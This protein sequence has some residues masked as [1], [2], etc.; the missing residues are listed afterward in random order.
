VE[1][2][3]GPGKDDCR[4]VVAETHSFDE[5][6]D[7]DPYRDPHLIEDLDSD[8]H[9]HQSTKATTLLSNICI[10]YS[11]LPSMVQDQCPGYISYHTNLMFSD[12]VK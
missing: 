1:S 6:Q 7:P 2:Q 5:E 3:N 8:P 4:P 12:K 11:I 9:Q 10:Q